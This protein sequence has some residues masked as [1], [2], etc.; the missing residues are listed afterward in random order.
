MSAYL[1]TLASAH[2]MP[3][4]LILQTTLRSG[5]YPRQSQQW[6]LQSEKSRFEFFLLLLLLLYHTACKILVP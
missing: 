6:P 1:C 5:Y 3:Y 2:N 4:F